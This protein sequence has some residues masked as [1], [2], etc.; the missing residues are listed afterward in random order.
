MKMTYD[1][2][3]SILLFDFKRLGVSASLC[4]SCNSSATSVLLLPHLGI[5]QFLDQCCYQ[6][7]TGTSTCPGLPHNATASL[8]PL[9]ATF[10]VSPAPRFKPTLPTHCTR[11]KSY[12]QPSNNVFKRWIVFSKPRAALQPHCP[13]AC[14]ASRGSSCCCRASSP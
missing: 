7:P 3:F 12:F 5:R 11:A 13:S 9:A 10:S 6:T 4:L 1:Y 14:A 8:F 2:A